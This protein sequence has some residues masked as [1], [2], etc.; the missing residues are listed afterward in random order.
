MSNKAALKRV[1]NHLNTLVTVAVFCLPYASFAGAAAY[2]IPPNL[3]ASNLLTPELISGKY[4]TV[5]EEV[6]ND[7]FM[8][9]Y[10]IKSKFGV[11]RASS[12]AEL[13]E[14]IR[15]IFVIA[16]MDKVEKSD[17]FIASAK[18]GGKDVFE[19]IANIITKPV[20]SIT[21]AVSGVG[22]MFKRTGAALFGDS[23][24]DQEDNRLKNLI[25]FSKTKRE[26]AADYG[27]DVYSSNTILQDHLNTMAWAGYT[28]GLG[29]T[30]T[31]GAVTGPAITFT[32]GTRL[33]GEIFRTKSPDD[34]RIMN[35]EILKTIGVSV[36][37]IDLFMAN[38]N[39]SPSQQ[40]LFV[41]ALKRI[42]GVQSLN[43]FVKLAV[44]SQD[45]SE[46]KFRTRQAQMYAAY[47]H[48][49]APITDFISMGDVVIAK[50]RENQLVVNAPVDYMVWT[51]EIANLTKGAANS[52][53]GQQKW[54]QK[55]LLIDGTMTAQARNSLNAQGWKVKEGQADIM[56]LN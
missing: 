26:Y 38:T 18:E 53:Q 56:K 25:G 32:G 11:I 43:L 34:L 10:L 14:R 1:K 54:I 47:H 48:K 19:G 9:Q 23:R 55:V 4:H 30:L 28:G 33:L 46:A 39:F 44:H 21:S 20:D 17:T 52:A 22:S 6:V 24:S 3:S 35:R 7:G 42:K 50:T 16:E 12:T 37:V 41:D 8:N 29:A 36:D 40:T 51:K 31:V 15:E 27:V 2:E 13:K 45:E 49:I 5:D